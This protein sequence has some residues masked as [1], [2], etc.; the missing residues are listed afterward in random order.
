MSITLYER[1]STTAQSFGS[2]YGLT[3]IDCPQA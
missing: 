3:A 1:V 2:T